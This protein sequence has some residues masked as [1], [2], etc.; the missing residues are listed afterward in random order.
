MKKSLIIIFS[1]VIVVLLTI[2]IYNSYKRPP[3][4]WKPVLEDTSFEYFN[5]PISEALNTIKDASEKIHSNQ[6]Q[7]ASLQLEQAQQALF[8]L[9]HYY[10]PMTNLRQLIYDADRLYYLKRFDETNHKLELAKKILHDILD[11]YKPDL[12]QSIDEI[13]LMIDALLLTIEDAP[14]TV[15][16]KFA[17]LGHKVNL[18]TVKGELIL[19]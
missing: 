7:D 17:K 4:P 19:K 15:P 12:T 5:E 13:I 16:D 10:V 8:K 9:Q 1:F 3:E 2:I 14:Q 18:M 11:S 6:D